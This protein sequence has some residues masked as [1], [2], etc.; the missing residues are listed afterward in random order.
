VQSIIRCFVT[1][2]E[3][4]REPQIEDYLAGTGA[5]RT[6]LLVELVRA[7]LKYRLQVGRDHPVESYLKRYPELED[8]EAAGLIVRD[9]ELRRRRGMAVVVADYLD[10]FPRLEP[11]LTRRFAGIPA[12]E[13]DRP[14]TDWEAARPASANRVTTTLRRTPSAASLSG[15]VP[16]SQFEA[17]F[18]KIEKL[19]E[20]G[21]GEV[22]RVRH[23]DLDEERAVKF[24][25]PKH[26]DSSELR[27]RLRREAQAMAR[28]DHPHAVRVYDVC[29]ED[30]PY[31][32]ME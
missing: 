24:I 22:W 23:R 9:Y 30:V 18:E 2:W 25:L 32:E 6:A 11:I 10:R 31:I 7:D 3:Q 17:K 16:L 26:A 21:M 28:V 4:G 13:S 15:A 5:R 1:E 19:G 27:E 8:E 20:G 14:T 29:M 12:S